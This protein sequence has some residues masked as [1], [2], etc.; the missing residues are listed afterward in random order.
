MVLDIL[1]SSGAKL[2]INLDRQSY[3]PGDRIQGR[4]TL[5]VENELKVTKGRVVILCL[6]KYKVHTRHGTGRNRY[7]TY[8][9]LTE[10]R[11]VFSKTILEETVLPP[12]FYQNYDLDWQVASDA[13]PSLAGK[14]IKVN[15]L[16]RAHLDRPRAIDIAA[17]SQFSVVCPLPLE[18]HDQFTGSE[19]QS[20]YIHP[21]DVAQS[22]ILPGVNKVFGYKKDISLSLI[23]PRLHWELGENIA[24]QLDIEASK[25]CKFTDI[26]LELHQLEEVSDS[27]GNTSVTSWKT[28]LA[29]STVMR[30]GEKL[31]LPFHIAIP[32]AGLPSLDAGNRK[33]NWIL[34]AT[35]ARRLASDDHISHSLKLYAKNQL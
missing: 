20:S 33:V 3:Q 1:K 22:F 30:A 16:A 8:K 11:E 19:V 27:S 7:D 28:K 24:G 9:W 10:T 35:L 29:G 25:E 5:Q 4:V 17:E 6:V 13:L 12:R 23:I 21:E 34:E 31:S 18:Y 32:S 2:D 14:I 15:W 26:R